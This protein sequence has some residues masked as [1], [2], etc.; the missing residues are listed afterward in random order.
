M[1][2]RLSIYL[3]AL[4]VGSCASA[5]PE[6]AVKPGDRCRVY[7][8]R[9]NETAP[10]IELV[11]RTLYGADEAAKLRTERGTAKVMPDSEMALLI[12]ELANQNFYRSAVVE[13]LPP[14]SRTAISVEINGRRHS[15]SPAGSGATDV[16]TAA[17]DY[18]ACGRLINDTYNATLGTQ[19]G[20]IKG[21][22][23]EE[24]FKREQLRLEKEAE[25]RIQK[26]RRSEG[27]R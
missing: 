12:Q 7:F 4:L 21:M 3:L 1:R 2:S 19:H 8:Q 15:L 18:G 24:Y 9:K 23:G 22:T 26:A 27:G 25:E 13:D 17:A 11:N 16:N 5:P 10:V 20:A 14:G 6:L